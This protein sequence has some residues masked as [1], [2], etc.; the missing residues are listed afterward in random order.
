M[1]HLYWATGVVPCSPEADHCSWRS[2]SPPRACQSAAC[3]KRHFTTVTD[4]ASRGLI[5]E[6]ELKRMSHF[7]FH[8]DPKL[9]SLFLKT[10]TRLSAYQAPPH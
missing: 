6:L 3:L 8:V 2:Y 9:G 10:L 7:T 1:R 4:L 5:D